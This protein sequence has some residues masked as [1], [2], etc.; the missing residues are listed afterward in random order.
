MDSTQA[1][2]VLVFFSVIANPL[3]ASI[4]EISLKEVGTDKR[5]PQGFVESQQ[6]D[7]GSQKTL[8][9]MEIQRPDGGKDKIYYSV[10]PKEEEVKQQKEEKE[11]VEKSWDMLRNIIIIDKRTK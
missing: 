9:G 6:T 7:E 5:V 1:M 4:D 2:A 3:S 11:K 8:G 10:T